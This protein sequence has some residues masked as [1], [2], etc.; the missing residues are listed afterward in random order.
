ML[1]QDT[2]DRAQADAVIGELR[3]SADKLILRSH[4]L[5]EEALRLKQ[6]ADD[7]AQLVKQHDER[8]K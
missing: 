3:A 2:N 5:A 7:L 4:E 6:R 1:N 8:A